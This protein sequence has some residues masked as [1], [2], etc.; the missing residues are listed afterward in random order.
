MV[1]P[2]QQ[3]LLAG[4]LLFDDGRFFD[5]HEAWEE[6]W[7]AERDETRRLLLQGLIQIAAGFHKLLAM[8]QP[9]SAE[10]LLAKGLAKLERCPARLEDVDVGAFRERVRACAVEL[11][12]GRF[13]RATIPTLLRGPLSTVPT[14]PAAARR[15]S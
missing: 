1:E 6:H 14:V 3:I 7:L 8:N 4:A 13:D 11:T 9:E 2:P 15:R 12:A 10:R 5:A